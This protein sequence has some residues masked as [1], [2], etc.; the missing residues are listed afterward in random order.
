MQELC[1][2]NRKKCIAKGCKNH[3]DEGLF[4]GDLCAPCDHAIRNGAFNAPTT[5]AWGTLAAEV[6]ALR[7]RVAEL[8][9]KTFEQAQS[10]MQYREH[11][12]TLRA[13]LEDDFFAMFPSSFVFPVSSPG[14]GARLLSLSALI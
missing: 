8:S 6:S 7:E 13:Q 2:T 1:L 4:R 5:A 3:T 14:L 9:D 12:S 10:L 11:T